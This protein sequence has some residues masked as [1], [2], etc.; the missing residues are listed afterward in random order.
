MLAFAWML[1]AKA[2]AE[3]AAFASTAV[4]SVA[5]IMTP[6]DRPHKDRDKADL[7][8]FGYAQQLMREMGGFS[9]S[10]SFSI[11]SILTGAVTLYEVGSTRVVR[12]S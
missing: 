5:A 9:I 6:A 10:P 11:I 1:G 12:S 2:H 4:S 8:R 7:H 3:I